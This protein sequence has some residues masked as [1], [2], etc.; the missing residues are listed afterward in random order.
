MAIKKESENND[1]SNGWLNSIIFVLAIIATILIFLT[2]VQGA[3]AEEVTKTITINLK[4]Q[5]LS[6][7]ENGKK[8]HSFD[9]SSGANNA[10]PTGITIIR[11]KE[12]N[13]YSE[14][15][16]APLPY[17]L[18][19]DFSNIGIH[20]GKLPGYPASHGCIRMHYDDA[21]WLFNWTSIGTKVTIY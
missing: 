7:F 19:T 10:T 12:K 8:L 1:Y 4:M 16:N 17:C 18:W 14:D 5:K 21:K 20:A 6:C 3:G 9:I 13:A 15:Y 2:V 11:A